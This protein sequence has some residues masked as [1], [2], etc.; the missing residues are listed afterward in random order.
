MSDS[1]S[2]TEDF[3]QI[4]IFPSRILS[5]ETAQKLISEIYKVDGVIR[6]M[7]QGNRLPDRVC[8]GPGTGERVEHPL[9]KP[10]QIGDQVVE[11]KICVGRIRVELSNAE[12]KEQIREICE[13]LFPFPFEFREGHFLRRKP[14]VTDYA[15]LGPGADPRFLGMVDPKSRADQL[16]FIEKQEKQE[17]KDKNE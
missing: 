4:E 2:N 9:R 1:A 16:I 15:K 5:P 12:A 8:A 13:K 10:I 6:V 17:K 11:L 7:V 3:I 14:T